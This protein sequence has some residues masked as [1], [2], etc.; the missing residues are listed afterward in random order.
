MQRLK[1]KLKRPK[2]KF[3]LGFMATASLLLIEVIPRTAAFA[4]KNAAAP[5][6]PNEEAIRE[7]VVRGAQSYLNLPYIFGGASP[8]GFDCSG[9][10][11]YLYNKQGFTMP[12]GVIAMRPTLKSTKNPKK[13]DV[14]FFLNDNHV[15][16]HVG[17]YIDEERFIHAPKEGAVIRY[18]K[19]K[20]PYWQKRLVE[21]RSVL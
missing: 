16:G 1:Q 7:A 19:L 14:I 15:A 13:G 4:A 18:E 9:L 6:L 11:L 21:I 2:Y 3:W 12:H 17:I 5:T 20:H 8:T 10:V